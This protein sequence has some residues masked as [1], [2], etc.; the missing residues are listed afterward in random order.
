MK[1]SIKNILKI[2]QQIFQ[3]RN[4]QKK[5]IRQGVQPSQLSKDDR[6]RWLYEE[7]AKWHDYCDQL[8]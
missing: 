4:I 7:N 5:K 6:E 8:L 1:N 2:V 3:K